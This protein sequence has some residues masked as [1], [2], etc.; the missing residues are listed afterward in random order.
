MSIIIQKLLEKSPFSQDNLALF[1]DCDQSTITEWKSGE[2][3]MP[4][5]K[6]EKLCHLVG[7]SL[8]D[9]AQG[10]PVTAKPVTYFAI[11]SLTKEDMEALADMN[12]M[13]ANIAMLEK[14]SRKRPQI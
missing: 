3:K 12:K 2:R 4:A 14:L 7:Y 6:F 9:Y 5:E 13:A 1:L 11:A 10:K 8:E